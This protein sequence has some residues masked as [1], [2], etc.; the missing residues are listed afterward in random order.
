MKPL[1][2][3]NRKTRRTKQIKSFTI[4]EGNVQTIQAKKKGG[5]RRRRKW[6]RRREGKEGVGKKRSKQQR[7]EETVK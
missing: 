4:L 6:G 1:K 3:Q 2:F 7:E 5:R